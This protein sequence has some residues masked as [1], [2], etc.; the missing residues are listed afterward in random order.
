MCYPGGGITLL[1]LNIIYSC[2]IRQYDMIIPFNYFFS[3][4]VTFK[5]DLAEVCYLK[6]F[7]R[8]FSFAM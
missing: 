6:L 4:D 5:I 2:V 7:L 8:G 1:I 3:V